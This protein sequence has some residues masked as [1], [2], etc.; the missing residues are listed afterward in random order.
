M[1]AIVESDTPLTVDSHVHDNSDTMPE[2]VESSV[3]SQISRYSFATPMIEDEI[4][5]EIIDSSVI[6]SC[7]SSKSPRVGYDFLVVPT[8]SSSSELSS[9]LL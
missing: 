9:S 7:R 4:D 6:T 8:E 5:H 1:N 2:L 3:S